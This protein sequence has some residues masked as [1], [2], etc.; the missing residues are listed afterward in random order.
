[1][2]NFF[3]K[4]RYRLAKNNQFFKY[5]RYAIGEIVLVVIGILIALQINSWN[6]DRINNQEERRYLIRLTDEV[7]SELN[8][9]KDL[10]DIFFDRSKGL[11]RIIEQWQ[12]G[13]SVVE[14]TTQYLQD[15][16]YGSG[17]DPWYREP[18]TWTQLQQSG[19]L[20]LLKNKNL[21]DDLFVFYSEVNKLGDN[22]VLNPMKEFVNT[23]EKLNVPL[24]NDGG[25]IIIFK[26]VGALY[27]KKEKIQINKEIFNK[28]W[29]YREELLPSFVRVSG[30]CQFQVVKLQEVIETGE[31]LLKKLEKSLIN[32]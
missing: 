3:R 12:S 29:N 16:S 10:R 23:R 2:I 14:D 31:V 1:M 24:I 32:N 4:I 22:F 18:I 25:V 13:N 21:T 7:R 15:Y 5:S 17:L 8:Y 30:I 19:D 9:L 11:N 27:V 28:I 20:N 26:Y 6:A